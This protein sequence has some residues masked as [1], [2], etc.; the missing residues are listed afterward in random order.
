MCI[1][2]DDAGNIFKQGA[3]LRGISEVCRDN[4]CTLILCHHSKKN[5]LQPFAVPELEDIA[6]AAVPVMAVYTESTSK[7][8]WLLTV[9]GK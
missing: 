4:G 9:G 8:G 6:W 5:L 7:R 1:D 2:G 3:M